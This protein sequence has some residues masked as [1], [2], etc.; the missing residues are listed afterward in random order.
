M[1]NNERQKN[2]TNIVTKITNEVL[3]YC[4]LRGRNFAGADLYGY[5]FE[6]ADL[7]GAN[8]S[9]SNLNYCKFGNSKIDEQTSFAGCNLRKAKHLRT[10]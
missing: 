9:N 4:D 5:D 10:K 1:L 6:G 7:R 8:F 2:M 3:F